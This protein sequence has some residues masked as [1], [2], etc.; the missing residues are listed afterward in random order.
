MVIT[1]R[2]MDWKE[3]MATNL[4]LFPAGITRNGSADHNSIKWTSVYGSVIAA[5]YDA[6]STDGMILP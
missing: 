2:N 4:Y 5:G 3:D 1:G 6:G